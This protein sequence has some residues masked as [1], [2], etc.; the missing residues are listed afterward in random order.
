MDIIL[1]NG[2]QAGDAPQVLDEARPVMHLPPEAQIR[3]E[4]VTQS[5]CGTRIDF[6]YTTPVELDDANLRDAAGVRV[7]V[8]AHGDMDFD[9]HGKLVGYQ[10][11][12]ADPHQL[13][14]IR[15]YLSK[16]VANGQVYIAQP[17]EQ[18][19]PDQLRA[20]GKPWYVELD[21]HGKKRLKRA[22]IS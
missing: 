13:R 9:A 5:P 2:F 7:E 17:G 14:A 4:N 15:D 18:V 12:P 22:W 20:Q 6:S 21:Q 19:N 16:L 1:P 10:V 3:V 8:S 11:E